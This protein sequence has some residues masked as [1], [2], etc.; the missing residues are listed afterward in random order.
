M[1]FYAFLFNIIAESHNWFKNIFKE[2]LYNSFDINLESEITTI[3]ID[4]NSM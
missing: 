4:K 2:I 1:A 3:I